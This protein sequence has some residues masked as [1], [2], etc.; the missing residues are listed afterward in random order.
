MGSIK[1]KLNGIISLFDC[2]Y[3]ASNVPD[4]AVPFESVLLQD[5][6]RE[7]RGAFLLDA[8]VYPLSRYLS[9]KVNTECKNEFTHEDT[10]YLNYIGQQFGI[11]TNEN[12]LQAVTHVS[13]EMAN[14]SK[15]LKGLVEWQYPESGLRRSEV[16]KRNKL[17]KQPI[18]ENLY[19]I[20]NQVE[21]RLSGQPIEV[22]KAMYFLYEANKKF[23]IFG[24]TDLS[25][26]MQPA[27]DQKDSM[28]DKQSIQL[29]NEY[30]Q[31]AGGNL[32][33]EFFSLFLWYMLESHNQNA[34]MDNQNDRE[35]TYKYGRRVIHYQ[36]IKVFEIY[37]Q[38]DFANAGFSSFWDVLN[39]S[40]VI[41]EYADAVWLPLKGFM[42]YLKH[43][44][45]LDKQKYFEH[46]QEREGIT[47]EN[48]Q[49]KVALDMQDNEE[50]NPFLGFRFQEEEEKIGSTYKRYGCPLKLFSNTRTNFKP[51]EFKVGEHGQHKIEFLLALFEIWKMSDD[52]LEFKELVDKEQPVAALV[53]KKT[54]SMVPFQSIQSWRKYFKKVCLRSCKED[55]NQP[56]P[57][58]KSYCGGVNAPCR[59]KCLEAFLLHLQKLRLKHLETELKNAFMHSIIGY[60]PIRI[61]MP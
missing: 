50:P 44:I 2:D 53:Y 18:V 51:L 36:W 58:Y 15:Y 20:F 35:L 1:D 37:N 21:Q 10:D 4:M 26:G 31:E 29:A 57:Y 42:S 54:P 24:N 8:L 43:L 7:W 47:K 27:S 11:L 12:K 19:F 28:N 49:M 56:F 40:L 41:K 22:I 60:E 32:E 6:P 38:C 14:P 52:S 25:Y 17:N 5:T 33:T 48:F 61:S 55:S 23:Y 59:R 46:L 39:E 16:K 13:E 9:I 30:M 34:D 45:P 3:F